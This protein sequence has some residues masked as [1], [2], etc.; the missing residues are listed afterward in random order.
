[1]AEQVKLRLK[2]RYWV[3]VCYPENMK[4]DWQETIGDLVQVPYA[5]CIHDKDH[6][7]KYKP[8]KGEDHMRKVHAHIM[9]AFPNTTTQNFALQTIEKL[10]KD[11]CKC[12]NGTIQSITN[13]RNQY[14]YLIHDTE[15]AR[16]QQKYKYDKSERICGNNFDI[17]AYEQLSLKEKQNMKKTLSDAIIQEGFTNFMD[18]HMFVTSNFDDE[19]FEILTAYS[20]FFEKLTRGN[21]QKFGVE[22]EIQKRAE[23]LAHQMLIEH[24]KNNKNQ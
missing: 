12:T 18:F 20:S 14:D 4:D 6:L 13:V 11:G 3:A 23:E 2:A 21:F 24:L 19:Y 17:G 16:R 8:K 10:A 9:L 15:T 7:A 1:M 5:Y 22:H